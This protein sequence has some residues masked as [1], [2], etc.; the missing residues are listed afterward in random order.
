MQPQS[1]PRLADRLA[2]QEVRETQ[3]NPELARERSLRP[4]VP[5]L[6]MCE[7]PQRVVVAAGQRRLHSVPLTYRASEK[8]AFM[9]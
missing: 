9:K 4:G 1:N 6:N 3:R 5:C 7:D 2:H 8:G